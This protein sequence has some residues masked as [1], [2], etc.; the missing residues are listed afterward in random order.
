VLTEF[1]VATIGDHLYVMGGLLGHRPSNAVFVFD[2]V[3]E[4]WS[5]GPLL[6]EAR[7]ECR[8]CAAQGSRIYLSGEVPLMWDTAIPGGRW[9]ELPNPFDDRFNMLCVDGH[10]M[11]TSHRNCCVFQ[12][13]GHRYHQESTR[14][15]LGLQ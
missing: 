7:Y 13:L 10:I 2:V 5:S 4:Q 14:W 8:A 11:A 1:A 6:P 12:H 3:T 15:T 9:V